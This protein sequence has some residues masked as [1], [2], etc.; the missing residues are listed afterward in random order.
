[1]GSYEDLVDEAVRSYGE[2]WGVLS[3]AGSVEC[4]AS[5]VRDRY[6]VLSP[7]GSVECQVSGAADKF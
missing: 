1:M 7:A 4:Q 3:L 5:G 6:K 2:L